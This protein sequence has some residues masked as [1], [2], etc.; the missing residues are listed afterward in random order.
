MS[1]DPLLDDVP[2]AYRRAPTGAT[3]RPPSRYT[4]RRAA[5]VVLPANEATWD[6]KPL[7]ELPPLTP[8]QQQVL[9]GCLRAAADGKRLVKIDGLAG[10]GKT[11]VLAHLARQLPRGE[12]CLCAKTGKAAGNIAWKTGLPASTIDSAAHKLVR[13]KP[14]SKGRPTPV[15]EDDLNFRPRFLI[16]DEASMIDRALGD[17]LV[18]RCSGTTFAF[19]DIGQLGP[20]EGEPWFVYPDYQLVEILRQRAGSTIINQ[21]R[22]VRHVGIYV[23][24]TD[25]FRWAYKE[26][27]DLL[28]ANM[29]I[30]AENID[31]QRFNRMIRESH[32]YDAARLYPGEPLMCWRNDRYKSVYNGTI[33][34]VR[35]T[36]EPGRPL[37]LTDHRQIEMN[38]INNPLI[39]GFGDCPDHEDF[40]NRKDE[41][42]NK[43]KRWVP[44]TLGYACTVHK[45][46]G[47]EWNDVL[48]VLRGGQ[49]EDRKFLYTA[50]TR[51]KE[52]ITILHSNNAYDRAMGAYTQEEAEY[53]A[54]NKG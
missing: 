46:Q 23:R 3:H 53:D 1:L 34:T 37:K 30:C 47:S 45:A 50:I 38:A 11:V 36:W 51:A 10:T 19:G 42:T 17:K 15:L 20:I 39:E 28:A 27:P 41:Q 43:K 44:F 32:G 12:L 24:H 13:V 2:W 8:H 6:N 9:D 26:T 29:V 18:A 7:P 54:E 31:R 5:A 33:V 25:D 35:E 21:A 16:I 22:R 48:L 49:M 40:F 52:K 4:P 14:N